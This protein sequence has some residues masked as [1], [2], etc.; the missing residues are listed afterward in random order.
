MVAG[1]CPTSADAENANYVFGCVPPV[2][3]SFCASQVT[4]LTDS[5]GEIVLL[6]RSS[7][8]GALLCRNSPS[9]DP[10]TNRK[11]SRCNKERRVC[12]KIRS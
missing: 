10:I 4:R 1:R 12:G 2:A 9:D 11:R 8:S 5:F 7:G 6:K 3:Q